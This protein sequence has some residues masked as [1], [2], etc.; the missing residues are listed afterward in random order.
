MYMEK[1]Q[2]L[3]HSHHQR[4]LVRLRPLDSFNRDGDKEEKNESSVTTQMISE[5]LSPIGIK[6]FRTETSLGLMKK[7]MQLFLQMDLM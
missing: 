5:S 6:M 7:S 3:Q 4:C 1:L 2:V